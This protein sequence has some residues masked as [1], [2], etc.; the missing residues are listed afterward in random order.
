MPAKEH[1]A[2]QVFVLYRLFHH[3]LLYSSVR[4]LTVNTLIWFS[5]YNE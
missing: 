5:C 3:I 1:M 2:P 4:G